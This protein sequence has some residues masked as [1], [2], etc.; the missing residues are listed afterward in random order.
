M[1]GELSHGTRSGGILGTVA[2]AKWGI[3]KHL[4]ADDPYPTKS[5]FGAP[6]ETSQ[7]GHA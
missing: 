4:S 6:E 5:V 7:Q 2:I 1:L 3:K